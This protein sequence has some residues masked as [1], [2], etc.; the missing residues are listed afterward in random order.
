MRFRLIRLQRRVKASLRLTKFFDKI[1]KG[2]YLFFY[3]KSIRNRGFQGCFYG[4]LPRHHHA[5][6][7]PGPGIYRESS[8]NALVFLARSKAL[9]LLLRC[10][11]GCLSFREVVGVC[12]GERRGCLYCFTG[13][14]SNF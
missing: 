4:G 5:W 7:S 6:F 12:S 8:L 3:N 9:S 11:V 1:G 13:R 2:S 14:L 10:M